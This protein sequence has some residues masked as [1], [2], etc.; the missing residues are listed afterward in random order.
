MEITASPAYWLAVFFSH[1]PSVTLWASQGSG[2]KKCRLSCHHPTPLCY[3][4]P[5]KGCPVFPVLQPFAIM[6][7]RVAELRTGSDPV[8]VEAIFGVSVIDD[9]E[10]HIVGGNCARNAYTRSSDQRVYGGPVLE[11]CILL[12]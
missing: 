9:D 10:G 2:D 11:S 5:S 12:A 6:R 8:G 7:P 3:S 1:C 4:A